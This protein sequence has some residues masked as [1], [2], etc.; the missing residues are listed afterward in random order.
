M[1]DR[2]DVEVNYFQR[3]VSGM[4]QEKRTVVGE[5][6]L[7]IDTMGAEPFTIM[8]TPG[9]D[10]E[11][12]VGFLF[13]EGLIDGIDDILILEDC[14]ESPDVVRVKIAGNKK[15]EVRRNLV[16]NSSCGLCGRVDVEGLVK[17]LGRVEGQFQVAI[18]VLYDLPGN[19]L[20]RQALFNTTGGSH[21]AALFDSEGKIHVL[22][23]DLGRHNAV[24]K[25]CG[26]AL[27]QEMKLA[28][29]GLFISGRASLE[30]LVKAGRGGMALVAAVGA[31]STMAVEAAERLGITLCGFV[32][33][34]EV[35]V[36]THDWRICERNSPKDP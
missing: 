24:D 19:S 29:M 11:L 27:L 14:E 21:A 15:G 35:A 3:G 33:G 26:Y 13:S 9:Q 28:D 31:A 4:K 34:E 7:V 2:L 32:R 8:R 6:P 10:R 36:Y 12:V 30:M 17:E 5:S 23:E 20:A 22:R 18:E 16:V 1:D 25:A